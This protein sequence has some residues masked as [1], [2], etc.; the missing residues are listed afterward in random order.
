M[1]GGVPAAM[2]KRRRLGGVP[3]AVI[4]ALGG[5]A[6]CGAA[7][8]SASAATAEI[9][10]VEVEGLR[11]RQGQARILVFEG[12]PAEGNDVTLRITSAAAIVTD[13]VPIEAGP[14]CEP[15]SG[16]E[17]RC[18]FEDLSRFEV[19]Y[20]RYGGRQVT[21]ALGTGPD[22]AS[23]RA[24]YGGGVLLDGGSGD[25]VLT[26]TT[27]AT[28]R[29]GTG[30]D[31][32]V[33]RYSDDHFDEGA[34][35]NGSDTLIARSDSPTFD[36]GRRRRGV[37]VSLDGRRNDGEAG[38]RDLL[39]ST[40]PDRRYGACMI[41]GSGADMLRGDSKSNTL[42]GG[43]GRDRLTGE[44]GDDALNVGPTDCLFSEDEHRPERFADTAHGGPGNDTLIGNQG[45]N[46]LTGGVGRDTLIGGAG[47]DR[48]LLRD[49]SR[50]EASCG[51]GRDRAVLDV[52]DFSRARH[53]NRC[54]AVRRNGPAL[55]VVIGGDAGDPGLA[56]SF[57]GRATIELG[58]PGDARARCV[59]RIELRR[60]GRVIAA[61]GFRI[62]RGLKRQVT[63]RVSRRGRR[64][65]GGRAS[66]LS[67]VSVI[68][69]RDRRGV[70]RVAR[71][72]TAIFDADV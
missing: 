62:G 13:V 15:G 10:N 23:A 56:V 50:D 32:M 14:G 25:D 63:M 67:V 40:E 65:L 55:A 20:F 36:Y 54:E 57:R 24:S 7:P 68:R 4:A 72:R 43:G 1:V 59:G 46:T 41:G 37:D 19:N 29:G 47:A 39:I 12:G 42:V 52:G 2:R 11:G 18:S 17:V 61:G 64:L 53:R 26:A 22:R 3:L 8:D 5:F 70:R 35:R 49:R 6:A 44:S 21:L 33:G 30:D 69:G 51:E 16:L 31:R 48:L 9:R 34:R 27:T 58:C 45:A 28:Y 60:R 66:E 38:E 71:A